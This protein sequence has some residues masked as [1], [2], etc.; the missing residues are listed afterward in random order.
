MERVPLS[1]AWRSPMLTKAWQGAVQREARRCKA[2]RARCWPGALLQRTACAQGR[3]TMGRAGGGC[4]AAAL[5]QG[6]C[7]FAAICGFLRC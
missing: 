4:W 7:Y 3:G 1:V 5:T 2:Q 6:L